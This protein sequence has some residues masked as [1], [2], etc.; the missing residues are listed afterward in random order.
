MR[1]ILVVDDEALLCDL[2]GEFLKQSGYEVMTAQ[3]VSTALGI[4]RSETIDLVLTDVVMP[5]RNGFDLYQEARLFNPTI[6]F[7]FFTGYEQDDLIINKLNRLQRPWLT[8]PIKL[9]ELLA[10]VQRELKQ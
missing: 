6:P 5:G 8:K 3:D 4:I 2:Y 10:L 1:R 7:I 9:D